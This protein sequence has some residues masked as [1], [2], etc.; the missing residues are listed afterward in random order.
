MT[1][2]ENIK[3]CRGAMKQEDLAEI[4]GVNVATLSRWENNQN[5]PNAKRIKQIA[6]ALKVP[7]ERIIGDPSPQIKELNERSLKEDY[8]IMRYKFNNT[9][10]LEMPA[11]PDFVPIFKQIISERLKIQDTAVAS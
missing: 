7:T 10:V 2:G 8:G 1:I 6:E 4:I 3:E 9:E 5:V 11:T